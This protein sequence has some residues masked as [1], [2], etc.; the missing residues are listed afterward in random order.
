MISNLE[1]LAS[2]AAVGTMTRAAIELRITQSA[3]SKR[4]A[5]LTDEVGVELIERDGRRVR[6]TAAG[7]H[8]LDRTAPLLAE[9]RHAVSS[10]SSASSGRLVI[11]VSESIL[12][13]WGARALAKARGAAPGLTIE[14][15]AHR[16]P[17]AIDRVRAGD[18]SLA[19]VAG[20]ADAAG[21]LSARH[22]GDEDMVVVPSSLGT[23]RL[24]GTIPVVTIEQASATWRSLSSQLSALRRDRG[25]RFDVVDSVQSFACIVQM[26]RAGLG[27]GLV[28]RGIARALG[29][30]KGALVTVPRPGLRRPVSVVARASTIGRPLVSSM[31][32]ALSSS[33]PTS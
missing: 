24:R 14:V 30:P 27:H 25:V 8:L 26:A 5:A 7:R 32:S 3:V 17:V 19:L 9:L 11:G 23:L 2:L 12:S 10:E 4:I 18:Y 15:N 21:E 6:L 20:A 16:S 1:T 22:I 31:C 28:P 33:V 13:S 29:V